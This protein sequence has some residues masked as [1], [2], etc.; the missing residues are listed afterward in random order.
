MSQFLNTADVIRSLAKFKKHL[1]IVGAIS[2]VA[3]V[4]FSGPFFIKPLFKSFAIVYPSNLISY[5]NESPTE[6]MLQ[7]FQSSEIR[8]KVIDV[9]NL[10]AHYKIDTV[11][12][13]HQLTDVIKA[14]E[15]NV[16][17]KQTEYESV[18][19]TV[20][21]EDPKV[22]SRMVDSIVAYFNETTRQLQREKSQE[23]VV[24]YQNLFADKKKEL[25]S[26]DALLKNYRTQYGLLDY[27]QQTREISRAYYGGKSSAAKELL[28][29]LA[30]HGGEFN[31]MSEKMD[32][33]LLAYSKLQFDYE[34]ALKDVSKVLTYSNM[35]T[36]PIPADKKSTP[37]RWLIVMVSVVS[38]LFVAFLVL[39]FMESSRKSGLTSR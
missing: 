36:K 24:I 23:V 14:Y 8:I 20:L 37:I 4:V 27:K 16:S 39:L 19:I 7:L 9:F 2:L 17:I 35:V 22:A 11:N 6:Q 25:D 32:N 31:A 33:G 18:Q 1:I 13:A 15:E 34:N 38:T 10:K 28:T 12:N 26:L 5:S 30:T 21:D 29:A 3:S